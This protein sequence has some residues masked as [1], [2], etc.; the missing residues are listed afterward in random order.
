MLS[1]GALQ[2]NSL[3]LFQWSQR[4]F[5]NESIL[6]FGFF[7]FLFLS[8]KEV[9][10]LLKKIPKIYESLEL[11]RNE[12][13]KHSQYATVMEN[14][15][16]IFSVQSSVAKTIQWIEEDK[17]L[18]AHQCLTDL[19]NSR[20]DILFELHKLPKQYA[21]DKMTLKS[22]FAK[23]EAVSAQ[24]GQKIRLILVRWLATVRK[25]PTIIVTAM[26][27]IKRE[28]TADAFAMQQKQ[29]TG[30]IPPGRPKNWRKM[31]MDAL[32]ETVQNRIEGSKLQ[33][34][35]DNQLWLVKDLEIA[36]QFILEDL[37]VVKQCC[38]PCFPPEYN[39]FDEFVKMYHTALSNHV[40]KI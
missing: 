34:R 11:V 12:N 28:E 33:E 17:L 3:L 26:R 18:N 36:R 4:Y 30:F 37:L 29:Q 5:T 21:L 8:T 24:L 7:F 9:G 32:Y 38:V 20:D 13:A 35:S 6:F 2:I 25:E 31:A 23:V 27:I 14:L 19:E 1:M 22:N 16:H 39:I 15:K 40:R 10:E